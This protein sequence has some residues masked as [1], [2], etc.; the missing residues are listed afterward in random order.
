MSSGSV[1][2]SDYSAGFL[3]ITSV[4]GSVNSSTADFLRRRGVIRLL[5]LNQTPE[6]AEKHIRSLPDMNVGLM[7]QSASAR[8]CHNQRIPISA[9]RPTDCVTW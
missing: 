6:W 4:W 7:N 2:G 5:I 3:M 1:S 8:S 9:M